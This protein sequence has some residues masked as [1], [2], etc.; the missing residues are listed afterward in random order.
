MPVVQVEHFVQRGAE[1]REVLLALGGACLARLQI[2]A[3]EDEACIAK[4]AAAEPDA[5]GRALIIY[6]LALP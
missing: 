2:A 4:P 6:G 5:G 3:I 1:F